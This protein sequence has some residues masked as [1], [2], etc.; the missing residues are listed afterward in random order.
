MRRCN[1]RALQPA[2]CGIDDAPLNRIDALI[3]RAPDIG[4]EESRVTLDMGMAARHI[5][6]YWRGV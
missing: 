2:Q 3:E 1:R 4:I 5:V 6:L